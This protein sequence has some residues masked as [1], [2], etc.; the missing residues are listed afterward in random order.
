MAMRFRHPIDARMAPDAIRATHRR[1]LRAAGRSRRRVPQRHRRRGAQ[2][3]SAARRA[4]LSQRRSDPRSGRADRRRR[5][6]ARRAALR[7]CRISRCATSPSC[8]ALDA[9]LARMTGEAGVR[10]AL[11]I[12]GDRDRPAGS[13]RSALEAIDCGVL[14]RH[15]IGE[16]GIAGYP[17]GHARISAAGAR[18]RPDRQDRDRDADRP[19]ASTS[20]RSSASTRS[21]SS[22]GSRRLRDFGVEQPVQDRA[23]RPD[24]HGDA[25]A[26]C[27]P[28]RRTAHRR[29]G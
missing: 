1:R 20:S 17:D 16:I 19:V 14:Q 29:R 4:R 26:L 27:T 5:S 18:S 22:P 25:A 24:Q 13:F 10:R 8:A 21:R 12:A 6:V 9:F 23:R 15:G 11:V 28:L 3:H 2:G 7:R